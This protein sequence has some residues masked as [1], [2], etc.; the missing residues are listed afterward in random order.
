MD[1][2]RD[3]MKKML[4]EGWVS[5]ILGLR[6]RHGHPLPYLF[7]KQ[8]DLADWVTDEAGRYPLTKLLIQIS[9]KYPEK[10]IGVVVRSCEQRSLIEL[11]KNRQLSREKVKTLGIACT[12]EL[13]DRCRCRMPYPTEVAGGEL[14]KPVEDLSD[15]EEV[16]RLPE[17][18]RFQYWMKQFGK[19]IKCYGCRNICPA[20][21]CPACTLE[22]SALVKAGGMPP[23]VPIFHLVK[24]YHMADRC[25]DC[26]LCEEA[27]PMGIPVRRL[28]RKVRNSVKDLFGYTP[29]ETEEEKG[30]LEF[31][32]DGSYELPGSGK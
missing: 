25:I 21:F 12:R 16:E 2:I 13:A 1:K 32:G 30:P 28:Y 18:E 14:A 7:T 3:G 9:R 31:L 19:C 26:G 8:E 22:D 20:C 29:G 23:E 4:E 17:E 24:A 6:L 27:C 15:I 5:G 10:T 11:F